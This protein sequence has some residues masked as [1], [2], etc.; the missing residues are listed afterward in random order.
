MST[1]TTRRFATIELNSGYVWWVGDAVSAEDACKQ[2][3]AESGCPGKSEYRQ[4][5]SGEIN[6]GFSV[7]AVHEVPDGFYLTD[8]KDETQISAV[9]VHPLVGYFQGIL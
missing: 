8:G 1:Q 9:T 2:S 3:D 4:V 6:T 7:Y 5:S